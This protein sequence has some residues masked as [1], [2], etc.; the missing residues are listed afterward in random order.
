MPHL[1]DYM[2]VFY[3]TKFV[4][5]NKSLQFQHVMIIWSSKS[6]GEHTHVRMC[7]RTHIHKH[8]SDATIIVID[9]I[10]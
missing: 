10:S 4:T 3:G 8:T 2:K 1:Q 5:I 6:A 9:D 7:M